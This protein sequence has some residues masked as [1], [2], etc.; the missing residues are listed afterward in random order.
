MHRTLRIWTI[1]CK[2][3]VPSLRSCLFGCFSWRATVDAPPHIQIGC[4][5]SLI[6]CICLLISMLMTA[7]HHECKSL[8]E[9]ALQSKKYFVV[10]RVFWCSPDPL[11]TA[12]PSSNS[13]SSLSDLIIFWLHLGI[14]HRSQIIPLLQYSLFNYTIPKT[15]SKWQPCNLSQALA[16]IKPITHPSHH[17]TRPQPPQLP[18]R[19]PPIPMIP[20]SQRSATA[21]PKTKSS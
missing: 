10:R 3:S 9:I 1:F 15:H 5:H 8:E 12:S 17:L 16:C 19:L 18:F 20:T 7:L 13:A 4:A 11:L 2:G 21:W 14:S 6:C